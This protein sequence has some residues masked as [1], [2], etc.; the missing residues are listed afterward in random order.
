MGCASGCGLIIVALFIVVAV[1]TI[2]MD[3]WPAKIIAVFGA[4]LGLAISLPGFGFAFGPNPVLRIGPDGLL[5]RPFY[6]EPVPWTEITRVQVYRAS[7][8]MKQT[9]EWKRAP[10]AD[11]I[12]LAVL[13][14]DRFPT[15]VFR[16]MS[17][18]TASEFKRLPV[19]LNTNYIDGAPQAML[20][21]IQLYWR[22]TIEETRPPFMKE[23]KNAP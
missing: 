2:P 13:E 19:M 3:M 12:S 11:Q 20:D 5:Y 1:V 4:V 9:R 10:Q 16:R 7:Y 18:H 14:P 8:W 15:G 17:R 21:A 23:N 22:G 6:H